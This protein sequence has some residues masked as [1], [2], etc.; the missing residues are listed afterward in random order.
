MQKA[1]M[2]PMILTMGLGVL[3]A[4]AGAGDAAGGLIVSAPYFGAIGAAGYSREQEARADQAGA[5]YM[6]KRPAV[7]SWP[8]RILQQFPLSGSVF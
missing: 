2:V 6:G 1:G 5:T 3:A 4:M 7:G 8:R